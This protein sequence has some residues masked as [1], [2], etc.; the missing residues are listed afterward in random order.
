[1]A[2]LQ[3]TYS[4]DLTQAI[5]GKIWSEIRKY[6][7][8]KRA[9]EADAKVKKAAEAL[10]REDNDSIPVVVDKDTKIIFTNMFGKVSADIVATEGKVDDVSAKVTNVAKSMVDQQ[11]LILNQNAMLEEKFDIMLSLLGGGDGSTTGVSSGR[12]GAGGG[13]GSI[14]GAGGANAGNWMM[15]YFG[16]GLMMRALK[17]AWRSKLFKRPRVMTKL[18]KRSANKVTKKLGSKIAKKIGQKT[19]GKVLT[20]TGSK[21]LSKKIP[22]VGLVAGSIF[23]A[24]RLA[25]GDIMGAGL[26]FMSG[27]AGTLPGWG[28]VASLALDGILLER[29]IKGSRDYNKGYEAGLKAGG[30]GNHHT[31]SRTIDGYEKGT[32]DNNIMG[33]FEKTGSMLISAVMPVAALTGTLSVVKQQVQAAGLDYPI[34]QLQAPS[35]VRIGKGQVADVSQSIESAAE[36]S[37]TPDVPLMGK[38]EQ[39][40]TDTTEEPDDGVRISKPEEKENK[41]I[42]GGEKDDGFL[43]PKWLGIKNPFANK[44]NDNVEST[45]T[46]SG[47]TSSGGPGPVVGRVGTTGKST[48]PHIHI[49]KGDGYTRPK[50]QEQAHIPQHIFDNIIVGGKPLSQGTSISN[51]GMRHHPVDKVDRFHAGYDIPYAEGT[52]I[53]LTGGLKMVEY[54]AGENAGFGNALVIEDTGGQKYMIAHLFSGP[55]EGDKGGPSGVSLNVTVDPPPVPLPP[56]DINQKSNQLNQQSFLLEDIEEPKPKVPIVMLANNVTARSEPVI[57]TGRNKSKSTLS[58][59][60]RLMSLG[61]S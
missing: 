28:T 14:A 52:E 46:V 41:T 22:G 21:A 7:D 8:E 61:I 47:E 34:V 42:F 2:T 36:E 5:A 6:D 20:K 9:R 3:K 11:Q 59:E 32:G 4:G 26:E 57:I 12:G 40:T 39:Q 53:R 58:E 23:A 54:D 30:G 10:K 37:N 45:S 43:G 38:P 17:G 24:E 55:E 35:D 15:G 44:K 33:F 50:N 49:E 16:K 19:L 31:G 27:V 29:D 18:A 48:G 60:Y 13:A 56:I 25:E 1:M 51:P